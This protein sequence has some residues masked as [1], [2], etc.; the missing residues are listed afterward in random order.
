MIHELIT[1]DG[2]RIP[3]PP[4]DV[5]YSLVELEAVDSPA[6]T[7]ILTDGT[8]LIV[9]MHDPRNRRPFNRLAT[10][11]MRAV[12]FNGLI[13][14]NAIRCSRGLYRR[15]GDMTQVSLFDW[16]PYADNQPLLESPLVTEGLERK[17]GALKDFED[18]AGWWLD[19][20]RKIA[21]DLCEKNGSVTSD[22]IRE[23]MEPPEGTSSNI[24]GAVFNSDFIPVGMTPTR[25]PGGHYRK[26][27]VW[28][29]R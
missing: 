16:V 8:L 18:R 4:A 3:Y 25:R 11:F 19:S 26:I 14:G 6:V 15:V 12:G 23:V 13:M 17:R 9:T 22:D 21:K 1:T 20:A 2:N 10:K 7:E 5:T 27:R 28:R 29:V 24:F